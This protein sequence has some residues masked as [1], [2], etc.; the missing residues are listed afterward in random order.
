[1]GD[2]SDDLPSIETMI[3]SIQV[4]L[5]MGR[6]G[7]G[8]N[9]EE[10]SARRILLE[11]SVFLQISNEISAISRRYRCIFTKS[12]WNLGWRCEFR[13]DDLP[14]NPLLPGFRGGHPLPTSTGVDSG[15]SARFSG[16]WVKWLSLVDTLINQNSPQNTFKPLK[17]PKQPLKTSKI[18]EIHLNFQ[19]DR[20]IPQ[21][22][23]L[24]HTKKKIYIYIYIYLKSEWNALKR[25][26]IT[27]VPL[28]H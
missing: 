22:S 18:I 26:K 17:L 10:G 12:R 3:G 4:E 14:L 28:N 25:S 6:V 19:N 16:G 23:K 21:N 15:C 9:Q 1:M 11:T 8:W 27:E 2:R 7:F 20:E 5:G 24:P 13:L